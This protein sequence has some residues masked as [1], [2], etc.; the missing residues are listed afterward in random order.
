M[1]IALWI[2]SSWYWHEVDQIQLRTLRLLGDVVSRSAG[3][4]T[5]G[6]ALLPVRSAS[7]HT[8][9][10]NVPSSAALPMCMGGGVW[11]LPLKMLALYSAL[12]RAARHHP[13]AFGVRSKLACRCCFQQNKRFYME[14]VPVENYMPFSSIPCPRWLWDLCVKL[15]APNILLITRM[16]AL[17]ATCVMSHDVSHLFAVPLCCVAQPE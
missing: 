14:N 17:L 6:P 2:P 8:W 3:V 4:R 16:L 7:W 10:A 1:S 11:P 15:T 12:V 5:L 13:I 9:S